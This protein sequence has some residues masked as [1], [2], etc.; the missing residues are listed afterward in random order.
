MKKKIVKGFICGVFDLLCAE[1]IILFEEAKKVCDYLMVGVQIDPTLDRPHKNK[2]IQSIMERLIML[3]YCKLV[4]ELH[5]YSTET[6]LL[7]LLQ[8][9]DFDVRI[10]AAYWENKPFTG[11]D[12]PGMKE[13]CYFNKRIHTFSQTD[14]RRRVYEIE[15][16]NDN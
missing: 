15:K 11:H 4:D 16:E 10:L 14:L 3:K 8:N 7:E 6:E 2:P 1:H 12:L 5:V 13:K 9:L